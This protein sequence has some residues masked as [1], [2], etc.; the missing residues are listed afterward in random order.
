MHALLLGIL[1]SLPLLAEMPD[2]NMETMRRL[3]AQA[4]EARIAEELK[5]PKKVSM[6]K[7]RPVQGDRSAPIKIVTFSDFQCPFCKTGYSNVEEIRKK[8]GKKVVF[9]FRH[10]PLDFHPNALPAAK[11]FEAIAI[12][13]AKKAYQFHDQIFQNQARLS[14]ADAESYMDEVAKG[15]KINFQKMKK[16]MDSEV[17][18]KRLDADKAEA[19]DLGFTGTPGFVVAGVTLRGAYPVPTFEHIIEERLKTRK[20]SSKNK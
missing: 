3:K 14:G 5:N 10:L 1:F 4:E 18:T 19:K 9:A 6:P 17:V 2:Q 7:D 11:R 15:L 20:V 16:D 12:Q 13:S 8:Y